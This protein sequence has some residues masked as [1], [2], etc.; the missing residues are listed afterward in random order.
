MSIEDDS[1]DVENYLDDHAPLG[2]QQAYGRFL[3]W[4]YN[5]DEQLGKLKEQ[6]DALKEAAK[7]LKELFKVDV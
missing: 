2:V 4:A 3:E 7:V 5:A 1:M 6:V